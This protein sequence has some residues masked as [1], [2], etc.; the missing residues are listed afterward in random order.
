M[1]IAFT[2]PACGH[3]ATFAANQAGET[4]ACDECGIQMVVPVPEDV[5]VDDEQVDPE[6]AVWE[7][8][9]YD[10]DDDDEYEDDFAP[11]EKYG[12]GGIR[13]FTG[14]RK[15]ERLDYPGADLV[16]R[17][18]PPALIALTFALPLIAA[19]AYAANHYDKPLPACG[20]VAAW[21]AAFAL[22][23]LPAGWAALRVAVAVLRFELPPRPARRLVACCCPPAAVAVLFW[24]NA[25]STAAIIGFAL[26]LLIMFPVMWALF[27]LRWL[28]AIVT[29][30]VCALVVAVAGGAAGSA[31]GTYVHPHAYAAMGIKPP[32]VADRKD[33]PDEPVPPPPPRRQLIPGVYVND[34]GFVADKPA[35]PGT[36]LRLHETHPHLVGDAAKK[37]GT[38]LP[39]LYP[40]PEVFRAPASHPAPQT[41][42]PTADLADPVQ[43][44]GWI[45][46]PPAGFELR[47]D[48]MFDQPQRPDVT[49]RSRDGQW[50][51]RFRVTPRTQPQ[52]QRLWAIFAPGPDM[53][54][55]DTQ[56]LHRLLPARP[57]FSLVDLAG[58]VWQ[59]YEWIEPLLGETLHF[60]YYD[61]WYEVKTE[62]KGQFK[63]RPPQ[64]TLYLHNAGGD[65][66]QVEWRG[67]GGELDAAARSVEPVA[68]PHD[69]PAL[70]R[71]AQLIDLDD[72]QWRRAVAVL[73]TR[74]PR[75][76]ETDA[77]ALI[78]SDDPRTRA[79]A[80]ELLDRF[81]TERSADALR[82]VAE[83][84]D[85]Q[86]ARIALQAWKRVTPG[87]VS[88]FD[89]LALELRLS[90]PEGNF[91]TLQ[92]I[93]RRAVPEDGAQRQQVADLLASLSTTATGMAQRQAIALVG[94]W[95]DASHL[96]TLSALLA[97]DD[98]AVAAAALDAVGR[99]GGAPAA[100]TIVPALA[101][102]RIEDAAAIAAL[103]RIGAPAE[104]AALTLLH[105]RDVSRRRA[106][107]AVLTAIGGRESVKRLIPVIR[108]DAQLAGEARNAVILIQR[109]LRN[110]SA[111]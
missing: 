10:V 63:G 44:G 96:E 64:R 12:S 1:P 18:A 45:I 4:V 36:W 92:M 21:A 70:I 48:A 7:Q 111:R 15:F 23:V 2:C 33:I 16:D 59:R 100:E 41:P 74:D 76:A 84:D 68:G 29:C 24:Y 38:K 71:P 104:S 72:A 62:R 106:G 52:Q 50:F 42:Q 40:P 30:I 81:A 90:M 46:H 69:V 47:L 9:P 97:S 53:P 8:D 77:L 27:H 110:P 17:F 80:V 98:D 78:E 105:H 66:V 20:L 37:F 58:V 93:E 31:L 57:Q 89:E 13:R 55:P 109:R 79:R 25:G 88:A 3:D 26:G 56:L 91:L 6:D 95:G 87:Q 101:Q 34:D 39:D 32:P 51:L 5:D 83:G 85:K 73:F 60:R 99:I 107:I 49:W 28:E 67:L 43:L 86:L 61:D 75:Q 11:G 65:W 54:S 19:L 22:I 102:G 94:K 35:D 108:D 14:V 103:E 82:A